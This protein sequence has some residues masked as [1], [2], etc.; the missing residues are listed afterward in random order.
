M[1]TYK[2]INVGKY[3]KDTEDSYWI[4]QIIQ[5]HLLWIF[6]WKS[7]KIYGNYEIDDSYGKLGQMPFFNKDEAIRKLNLYRSGNVFI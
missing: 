6:K 3:D 7:R 1:K 4:E 5:H 2:L